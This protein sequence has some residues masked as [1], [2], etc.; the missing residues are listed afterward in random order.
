MK[1]F[2]KKILCF[3]RPGQFPG[4]P[5]E[6]PEKKNSFAY[7]LIVPVLLWYLVFCYAPMWGILLSFKDYKPLPGLCRQQMGGAEALPEFP[8]RSLFFRTIKIPL[9]LNVWGLAFGFTLADPSG[10]AA[11]RSQVHEV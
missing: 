7:L 11:Q 4:R 9:M 6:R 2:Q 8:F 10:V 5:E 3:Q 1:A